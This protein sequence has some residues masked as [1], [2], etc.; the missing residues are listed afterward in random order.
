[1]KAD[2]LSQYRFVADQKYS[3]SLRRDGEEKSKACAKRD[4]ANRGYEGRHG[5]FASRFDADNAALRLTLPGG[6][7]VIG[8]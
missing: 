6:H 8:P 1:L 5:P 7:L 4:E 2:C 3:R